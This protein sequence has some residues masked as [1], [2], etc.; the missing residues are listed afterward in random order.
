MQSL[1]SPHRLLFVPFPTARPSCRGMLKKSA[2][3]VLVLVPCSRTGSTL[4]APKGL[5]PCWT[6]FFDHSRRLLVSISPRACMC[7]GI[8]IFH[9]PCRYMGIILTCLSIWTSLLMLPPLVWGL[10]GKPAASSNSIDLQ[11]IVKHPFSKPIFLTASPDD[12]NHLFVVEQEGRILIVKGDSVLTTPFL[13]ISKK[14]STGGER[15]LLGLAFH[16]H[17]SSN[18]R[19]FVNYT[20]AQDRATVITEYRVSSNPNQV[21]LGRISPVSHSTAIRK[22]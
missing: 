18:G 16:P 2:S 4:R 20:R 9:S 19:L 13:D 3:G 8:E 12:T 17:F 10:S 14:L 6:D 11:A 21:I 15:G 7:H 1:H 5:R 22:S